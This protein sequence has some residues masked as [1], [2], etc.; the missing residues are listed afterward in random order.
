MVS[1]EPSSRFDQGLFQN[2]TPTIRTFRRR[3]Q[4]VIRH[5][6]IGSGDA[7]ENVIDRNFSA[8]WITVLAG[9]DESLSDMYG[10]VFARSGCAP[11]EKT[12]F[13]IRRA[14]NSRKRTV[15][16]LRAGGGSHRKEA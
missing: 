11:R 8:F 14:K 9:S 15:H 10:L 2:L 4:N 13:S 6:G 1:V 12:W 3:L 5:A 7:I 16:P